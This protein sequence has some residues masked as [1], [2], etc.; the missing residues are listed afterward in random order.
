MIQKV[1]RLSA[2][3]N[4]VNLSELFACLT[5]DVICRVALGKKYGDGEG[6]KF[7]DVLERL[8]VLLGSF[9]V[10]EYVPWLRWVE[11]LNGVR[12]KI[13]GIE[14][15]IDGVLDDVVKEHLD[16][17]GINGSDFVDVLLGIQ[18]GG[19]C[20]F[21]LDLVSIKALILVSMILL[22]FGFYVL[23]HVF[24]K[25]LILVNCEHDSSTL[26]F[27]FLIMF[28]FK[29][30]SWYIVSIILLPFEFMFLT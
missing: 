13:K 18:R 21:V 5:N 24:I 25:A 15:E 26:W 6:R 28:P 14:K 23:H 9:N 16:Q 8:G 10:G 30:S 17:E 4:V 12:E 20:G 1:R 27:M 2:G 19:E 7:K 3:E 11:C 22:S 29:F